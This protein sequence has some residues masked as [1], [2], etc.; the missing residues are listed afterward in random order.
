METERMSPFAGAATARISPSQEPVT[1]S[2]LE[3]V[4]GFQ[5]ARWLPSLLSDLRSLEVSGQNV[6]GLGDLRVTHATADN[7]RR[8]L[9]VIS[10]ASIPE[11]TLAPFSG[12]G[13]A[14]SCSSGDKELT[15]TAYPDHQDFVFSITNET[16]EM[17]QDGIITFE[18]LGRF[19]NV[20]AAFLAR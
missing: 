14:L 15:F 19:E 17:Y 3:R 16:D 12:G 9:T 13:V 6:P 7:V 11:P 8:L 4:V 1:T 18:Q 2:Q 5:S 10:G 20:I